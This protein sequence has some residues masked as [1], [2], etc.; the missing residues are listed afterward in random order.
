M[1]LTSLPSVSRGSSR[2]PS[3]DVWEY[4]SL[5]PG[6]QL[7]EATPKSSPCPSERKNHEKKNNDNFFSSSSSRNEPISSIDC[8]TEYP[9]ESRTYKK[10]EN[11][12]NN[13]SSTQ[14]LLKRA[15]LASLSSFKMSSADYQDSDL[16][17]LGSDSV[18][19][20]SYADTEDDMQQFSTDSDELSIT[21]SPP[22]QNLQTINTNINLNK[23]NKNLICDASG[24]SS[25]NKINNNNNNDKIKLNCCP[26]NYNNNNTA[27]NN[28][29]NISHNINNDHSVVVIPNIKSNSVNLLNTFE[30]KAIIERHQQN[31]KL[32][33]P[34][35]Y[36]GYTTTISSTNANNSQNKNNKTDEYDNSKLN[37]D[38]DKNKYNRNNEDNVVINNKNN[39]KTNNIN[40]SVILEL[41]VIGTQLD[42]QS[43]FSLSPNIDPYNLP[44]PS[45]RKWSKETLF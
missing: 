11:S 4:D 35:S 43:S 12:I 21:Q 9:D 44:G 24:A 17:S 37:I 15:P 19:A 22:N 20:E 40:P 28:N 14:N 10:I 27:S 23:K 26:N 31:D 8:I 5:C 32:V 41:P 6:I 38:I 13:S 1:G 33:R 2:R 18:F 7:T 16:R 30:T 42:D 29:I 34:A 36:S 39:D 45:S 3:R 25:E